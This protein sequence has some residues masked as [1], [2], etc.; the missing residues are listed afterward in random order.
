MV[1][2]SSRTL[3]PVP[4]DSR[5]WID[6]STIRG[7]AP[8]ALKQSLVDV[9]G[10]EAKLNKARG[11]RGFEPEIASRIVWTEISVL[12]KA[13]EPE[14]P[15]GRVVA[16]ITVEEGTVLVSSR[17]VSFAHSCLHV[18]A[19]SCT[20]IRYVERSRNDS[21]RVLCAAHRQVG[22]AIP[23]ARPALSENPSF[24]L[25]CSSM[26]IALLNLATTGKGDLGVSQ[27]LNIIYHA[28]AV[29]F[30]P[31]F[32]RSTA[33]SFESADTLTSFFRG[34]RLRIVSTT[35]ALGS[36][37]LSARC[38]VGVWSHPLRYI[39]AYPSCCRSGMSP[40]TDW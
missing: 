27:S 23:P 30:A 29:T 18:S 2:H 28:P 39:L 19:P 15:E 36:R 1:A 9:I 3:P 12:P 33:R 14:R 35:I 38:E 17:L 31:L 5:E 6:A 8:Q 40:T 37:A 7:N 24:T 13:E 26:P 32:S 16:E 10:V 11:T 34:D 21:W 25:S 20:H 22:S 4:M